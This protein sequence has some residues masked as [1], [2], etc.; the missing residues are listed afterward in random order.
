M[1]GKAYRNAGDLDPAIENLTKA[2]TL[3]PDHGMAHYHLGLRRVH[4]PR[5]S[6]GC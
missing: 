1:I 3:K 6:H 2:V 4:P 5:S